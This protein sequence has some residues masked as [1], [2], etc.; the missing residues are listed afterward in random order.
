MNFLKFCKLASVSVIAVVMGVGLSAPVQAL[1]FVNKDLPVVH[2]FGSELSVVRFQQGEFR[3]RGNGQWDEISS[4]TNQV[5][6]RFVAQSTTTNHVTLFDASRNVT[7]VLDINLGQILFAVGTPTFRPLYNITTFEFVRRVPAGQSGTQAP[8]IAPPKPSKPQVY[9][10]GGNTG[11]GVVTAPPIDERRWQHFSSRS[12]GRRVHRLD[13]GIP[14]TDAITFRAS[15]VRGS[16]AARFIIATNVG[17]RQNGAGA[18]INFRANGFVKSY[19]GRIAGARNTQERIAGIRVGAG[20]NDPIWSTLARK[21]AISYSALGQTRTMSLSGSSAAVNAFLRGCRPRP[22]VQPPVVPQNPGNTP[23]P[24][25]T[26]TVGGEISCNRFGRIK[27]RSSNRRTRVT[28]VNRSGRRRTI[29][30]I[31]YQGIPQRYG[32]VPAGQSRSFSTFV[33]HPWMAVNGPGDCKQLFLPRPASSRF[34]LRR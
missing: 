33:S 11:G 16:G 2:V 4:A 28:F 26:Q 19:G 9:T 7:L 18:T 10:P 24:P 34:V 12:Q 30:W 1:S 32:V 5:A 20:V 23:R 13:Y 14:E 22:V 6:Y 25:S 27:S 29:M 15:C 3:N 21:N 31:N 8:P 17:N